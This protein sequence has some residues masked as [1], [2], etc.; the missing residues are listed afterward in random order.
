M[1]HKKLK[2]YNNI[3]IGIFIKKVDI[4]RNNE[5]HTHTHEMNSKIIQNLTPLSPLSVIRYHR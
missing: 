4:N 5:L 1:I 3:I 2:L